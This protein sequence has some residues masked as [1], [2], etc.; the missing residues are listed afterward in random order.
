M[1]SPHCIVFCSLLQEE[2]S[3][4][5]TPGGAVVINSFARTGDPPNALGSVDFEIV[6]RN[7]L[8]FVARTNLFQQLLFTSCLAAFF[9]VR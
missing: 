6:S 4:K 7:N 2:K 9:R 8:A 5:S 1:N 3:P